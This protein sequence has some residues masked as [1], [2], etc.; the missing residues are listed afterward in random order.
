MKPYLA[1]SN[2]E[3]RTMPITDIANL[4]QRHL[5]GW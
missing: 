1:R 4:C 2:L 5:K 3:G